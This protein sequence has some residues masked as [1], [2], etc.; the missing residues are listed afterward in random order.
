MINSL[1][2]STTDGSATQS[3]SAYIYHRLNSTV[4][5]VS[6]PFLFNGN[7]LKSAKLTANG[8]KLSSGSD[9]SVSGSNV[10]FKSK[11]LSTIIRPGS[12]TGSL[13]NVTLTFSAGSPLLV[14]ILQYSTPVLGAST[15]KL[16]SPSADVHIPILWAGQ[17]RPAAV[18]AVKS[19]GTFLVDDWTQWLPA[20]QQ[21]RI[22]YN[23]QWNW[24]GQS[25]ILTAALVDAVRQSGKDTTFT[26]EFYPRVA[27]NAV[28]YTLTVWEF[29]GWAF[30]QFVIQLYIFGFLRWKQTYIEISNSSLVIPLW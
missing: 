23:G 28:N 30:Q 10:I 2:D 19:D 17:N 11:F 14:N 20:L 26:I 21:G 25:V 1:P 5:D 29:C 3:S 13:A 27:G 24:D 16:P 4:S 7:T 8:K 15:S 9:Y 22:T 12:Q 18:K 6:L